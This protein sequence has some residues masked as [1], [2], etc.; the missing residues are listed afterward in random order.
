MADRNRRWALLNRGYFSF[1]GDPSIP[2]FYLAYIRV[3]GGGLPLCGDIQLR[4][5]DYHIEPAIPSS[6]IQNS[7]RPARNVICLSGPYSTVLAGIL[8]FGRFRPFRNLPALCGFCFGARGTRV[9]EGHASQQQ[10]FGI[11]LGRL[12]LPSSG[13]C[14]NGLRRL[15]ARSH[16]HRISAGTQGRNVSRATRPIKS[17]ASISRVSTLR[18]T[19]RPDFQPV[20]WRSPRAKASSRTKAGGCAR[21]AAAFGPTS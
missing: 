21:T 17:S 3:V 2:K 5:A 13:R 11:P 14:D 12:S 9:V 4:S 6:R 8:C 10:R 16:G 19:R 1:V 7:M 15:H 18:K 20:R